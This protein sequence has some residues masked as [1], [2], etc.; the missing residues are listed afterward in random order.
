[1]C[2]AICSAT[3]TDR[4]YIGYTD[5]AP[6]ALSSLMCMQSRG[7]I[8]CFS[9]VLMV[10]LWWCWFPLSSCQ[11]MLTHYLLEICHYIG[12]TDCAPIAL[13]SLMCMQSRGIYLV[14]PVVWWWG[15]D[16]AG[17]RCYPASV[18][19]P[20]SARNMSSYTWLPFCIRSICICVV[21]SVSL[22]DLCSLMRVVVSW[23]VFESSRSRLFLWRMTS[24]NGTVLDDP[25]PLVCDF[26]KV[27]FAP[28]ASHIL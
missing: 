19:S 12:Y 22:G 3:T 28:S 27:S 14:S 18:C 7:I 24:L 9:S 6:I 8:P 1:M 26:V 4:R 10:G 21:A 17:F 25:A 2:A 23:W 16:D 20:L 13:P 5:C 11:S 15:Y